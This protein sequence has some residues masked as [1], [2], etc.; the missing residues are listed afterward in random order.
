MLTAA[1]MITY[2]N[3]IEVR[4]SR[5]RRFI[6]INQT[7]IIVINLSKRLVQLF[8]IR[9]S[10]YNRL[11]ISPLEMGTTKCTLSM[12]F[13]RENVDLLNIN[14]NHY[15]R[16]D[17]LITNIDNEHNAREHYCFSPVVRSGL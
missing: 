12:I 10:H 7:I 5:K 15:Q 14:L 16:S 6:T 9:I 11:V 4:I 8:S 1:M 2:G 13:T 17:P 3:R